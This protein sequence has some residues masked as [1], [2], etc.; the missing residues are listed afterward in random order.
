MLRVKWDSS[1][2]THLGVAESNSEKADNVHAFNDGALGA[3]VWRSENSQVTV[4]RAPVSVWNTALTWGGDIDVGDSGWVIKELMDH[5]GQV[6]VSKEDSLWYVSNDRATRVTLGFDTMADWTNGV[7]LLSWKLHLYMNWSSSVEQIYGGNVND[8]GPW[9]YA[10]LPSGRTG[11]IAHMLGT[12]A[13]LLAAID[14]D[15]RTSSVHAWNEMG[16]HEIF[17]AWQANRRCEYLFWQSCPGTRDRLWMSV[18]GDLIVMEQPL[19]TLNPLND[20]EYRY[21]HE[22]WVDTSSF[23]MSASNLTKLFQRLAITSQNLT[24][25]IEIELLYQID[26]EVGGSDWIPIKTIVQSPF[27][28]A[29]I[30]EGE[31]RRIR[32]R[33]VGRTNDADVPPVLIAPVLEGLT[34]T[35]NKY[36]FSWVTGTS[37]W[38]LHGGV[39]QKQN[40]PDDF[41]EWLE[42][43]ANNAVELTMHSIFR[44][45]DE[46]SVVLEPVVVGVRGLDKDSGE[47]EGDV[48]MTVREA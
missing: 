17:R 4:S 34:R 31:R 33:Y 25:G 26:A 24:Q 2:G 32:L 35:P 5:Q 29:E 38:A 44:R 3:V 9:K 10:G 42:F 13:F 15:D 27:D 22:W 7:A 12:H 6:Y 11:V 30:H 19:A 37:S 16:Y 48:A 39:G 36:A 20:D 23:D 45:M 8:V 47:W 41:V 28:T 46:I 43:C 1:T 18:G 14:A 40:N 21:H